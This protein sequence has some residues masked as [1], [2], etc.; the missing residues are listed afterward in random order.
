[1]EHLTDKRCTPCEG[2]TPPLAAQQVGALLAKLEGGWQVV[3]G[4]HLEKS[5]SFPDFVSALAFVD[6]VGE[7]A[8]AQGHHPDIYLTWGKVTL[9]IWT[10][11]VGGLSEN[12]F[13]LAAHADALTG[14]S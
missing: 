4:H 10:H 7:L 6:R 2:G 5:W 13:I 12:D 3:D 14:H 11:A 8:E 9:N 1:M